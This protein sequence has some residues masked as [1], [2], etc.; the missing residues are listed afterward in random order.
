MGMSEMALG[1]VMNFWLMAKNMAEA[2]MAWSLK[3]A[4]NWAASRPM[5]VR[6]R[7]E[8]AG[9]NADM[10]GPKERAGGARIKEVFYRAA[11]FR[12][13]LKLCNLTTGRAGRV[14]APGRG[15]MNLKA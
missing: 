10:R 5:N 15:K 1:A 9:S 2:W 13:T 11:D 7:N 14:N 8:E 12:E 4:R 6:D 3:A